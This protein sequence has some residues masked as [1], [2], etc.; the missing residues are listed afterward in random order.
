VG[1]VRTREVNQQFYLNGNLEINPQAHSVAFFIH[2]GEI[3]L[4][5]GNDYE[6]LC[7]LGDG[8]VGAGGGPIVRFTSG[9][10]MCAT[11]NGVTQNGIYDYRTAGD[12]L[13]VAGSP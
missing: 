13:T 11:I 8:Y 7:T 5:P 4:T 3:A 12:Y 2:H 9:G 6:Y 10:L 1:P